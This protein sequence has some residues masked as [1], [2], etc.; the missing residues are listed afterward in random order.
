MK[1]WCKYME[2]EAFYCQ[3]ASCESDA[4]RRKA[5]ALKA[6]M[7]YTQ[8]MRLRDAEQSNASA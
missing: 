6:Q 4:D 2:L 7:A 5:Y 8:A 3:K 1:D